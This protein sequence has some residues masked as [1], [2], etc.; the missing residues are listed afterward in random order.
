MNNCNDLNRPI[1]LLIP[2]ST[3]WLSDTAFALDIRLYRAFKILFLGCHGRNNKLPS[4]ERILRTTGF[5]KP[6]L[7]KSNINKYQISRQ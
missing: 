7:K 2:T 6:T 4:T 3:I 1:F 5:Y